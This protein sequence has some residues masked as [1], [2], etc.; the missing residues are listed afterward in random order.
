MAN[1]I[2]ADY[3]SGS[4]LYAVIRNPAGQVWCVAGQAFEDW[5]AGGHTADD[6]DIV[7]I[8]CDGSRYVGDFDANVPAGT[9]FVQVFLQAGVNP[10]DTDT[11]VSS[12][13]IFWTGVG[14]LTVMKA[15]MNKA[16]DD[17]LRNVIEY[18]D[19]DQQTILF[20]HVKSHTASSSSR[21]PAM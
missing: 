9:H 4:T 3:G 1:E 8:D 2:H 15:L 17:D 11:L 12:R 14:E 21:I 16:V 7:L 20:T 10:A 5:G 13:E 19:D 6:Y 18:Y